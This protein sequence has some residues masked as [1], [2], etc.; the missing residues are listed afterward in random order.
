MPK[1]N[2]AVEML[3]KLIKDEIKT[4]SR[5]NIVQA[6]L[7]SESVEKS[8]RK[9]RNRTIEAA[10]VIEELIGLAKELKTAQQRGEKLGLSDDEVAF[11]DA[12]CTNGSAESIMG[13]DQLRAL[14]QELVRRVRGSVTIDWTLRESARA[15]IRRDVKRL[16]RKYGYPPDKELLATDRII[17]QAEPL[18]EEWIK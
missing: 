15:A 8:I 10:M 17:Q 14:A 5:K 9:Y 11:Y 18:C 4:R 12:L 1:K 16:L 7:F 2:L 13:D 6:Q 3:H